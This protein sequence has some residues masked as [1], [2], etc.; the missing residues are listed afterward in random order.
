MSNVDESRRESGLA[1]DPSTKPRALIV[2]A[3]GQ[4]GGT[5]VAKMADRW[6]VHPLTRA[7]LNITDHD[8]VMQAVTAASPHVII[9]CAAYNQVDAAEDHVADAFAVNAFAVDSLARAASAV[10]ATLVHYSTDFV[11]DGSG[12]RPYTEEDA[13]QPRSVYG[14]SK[15]VGEWLARSA[16]R[17]YVIRVASLFGGKA[18]SSVDRI[19]AQIR[20]GKPAPAFDDRTT[21][22]SLVD[23]VADATMHLLERQSPG[24]VYHAVASGW[25][26]WY[27]LALTI[28]AYLERPPESVTPVKMAEV[29][30]TAPRPQFAALS[31][32]R[33]A[34]AGFVMPTWQ[35]ML[36]TYLPRVTTVTG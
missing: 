33:L 12:D 31:N 20:D 23:D 1:Q 19:I 16:P 15:L 29:V 34:Q 4:L 2:G 17:H 35:A 11:F 18:S 28:A 24:G 26:T 13:P 21:T 22:P 25:T 9:N 10:D 27:E 8:A 32:A 3:A 30:L 36:E 14:Q 5:M 7:E 6:S